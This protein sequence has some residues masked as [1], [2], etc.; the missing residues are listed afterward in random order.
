MTTDTVLLDH[1]SGGR[2]T[3]RLI[4]D[5]IRPRFGNPYLSPLADGAVL[6]QTGGRLAFST[7]SFVVDPIFFPGGD[8]GELAVNG[9]VNDLAVC[10]ANP[11]Y[12]SAGLIIEEGFSLDRLDRILESMRR[13]AAA[14]NVQIVTGDTKVVP[15]GA[16]DRIFINTA[17]IG[18]IPD[19]VDI[20]P[21]NA[22]PGDA[23]ILSGPIA[24][25]GVAILTEREGF[26]LKTPVVSD[27]APL[28]GLVFRLFDTARDHGGAGAIRALR[29]PT[30][31]GV[32]TTLCELAESADF[33]IRLTES[34]I[35]VDAAVAAVCELVGFDPLYVANE[36]KLIAVVDSEIAADILETMHTDPIARRAAVI[37]EITRSNSGRVIMETAVG[38]TRIIDML[39]G[40]QLPRIC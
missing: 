32:G 27:T 20:S 11:L 31:G 14:A 30:R 23:V 29:D 28:S 37:G 6:P 5:R 17:G 4:A 26:V 19:D 10:G 24:E 36:G 15:R 3:H 13:A 1:G 9:T 21:A 8:I 34:T 33:G 16:A 38:G 39:T 40:E 2:Q 12:L 18:V 25:H 35:P 22:R 7:D